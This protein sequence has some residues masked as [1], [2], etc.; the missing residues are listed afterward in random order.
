MAIYMP[1][2]VSLRLLMFVG[3]MVWKIIRGIIEFI[4]VCGSFG[5]VSDLWWSS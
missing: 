2:P 1:F 3:F 4:G 5:A